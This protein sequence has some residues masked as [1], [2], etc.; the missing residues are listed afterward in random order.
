M[1]EHYSFVNEVTTMQQEPNN[2]RESRGEGQEFENQE[3]SEN[4]S[5]AS[6]EAADKSEQEE[7][8]GVDVSQQEPGGYSDTGG[9]A[10]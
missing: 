10:Q 5:K 4:N 7:T 8:E 3:L 2:G 1:I 6:H 9:D